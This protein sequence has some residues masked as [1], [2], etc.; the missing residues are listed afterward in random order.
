M[1]HDHFYNP[2]IPERAMEGP[3]I[4]KEIKVSE[5]RPSFIPVVNLALP[6]HVTLS[7]NLYC[8]SLNTNSLPAVKHRSLGT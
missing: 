6:V 8:K 7:G 5:S 2:L 3:K 1:A 4:R